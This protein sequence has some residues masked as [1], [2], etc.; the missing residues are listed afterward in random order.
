MVFDVQLLGIKYAQNIIC[1][2]YIRINKWEIRS[3]CKEKKNFSI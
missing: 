2:K 1:S 3:K